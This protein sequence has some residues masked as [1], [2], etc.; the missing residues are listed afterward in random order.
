[1]CKWSRCN[2][3]CSRYL[4]LLL[5]RWGLSVRPSARL[6]LFLQCERAA[7][8]AKAETDDFIKDAP[9]PQPDQTG[10]WQETSGE[11]Q[12]VSSEDCLE[13]Q[14]NGE[15]EKNEEEDEELDLNKGEGPSGE[16]PADE[17]QPVFCA[18][19][20]SI[21]CL[22]ALLPLAQWFLCMFSS[23]PC[24][25]LGGIWRTALWPH[26]LRSYWAVCARGVP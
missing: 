22:Y 14:S 19:S 20:L 4:L 8:L 26:T 10:Q 25:M 11:I 23:Q 5:S 15:K 3:Q 21:C 7:A 16:T 1:M 12:W 6:Q 17:L 18:F 2:V 9:K 13:N 24:S